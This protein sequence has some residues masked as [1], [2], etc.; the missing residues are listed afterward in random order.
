M[1]SIHLVLPKHKKM[2]SWSNLSVNYD[3][4]NRMWNLTRTEIHKKL[5]RVKDN[6]LQYTLYF[7]KHMK[8]SHR[9]FPHSQHI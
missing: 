3:K 5:F 8:I 9:T 4:Y 2:N 7:A 1:T 6:M